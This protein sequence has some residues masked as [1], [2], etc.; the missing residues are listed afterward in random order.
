MA[1]T[2]KSKGPSPE[3]ARPFE[4]KSKG[5][6][7]TKGAPASPETARPT[8]MRETIESVVVAFILAFMFKTFEAE[9]F[10]RLRHSPTFVGLSDHQVIHAPINFE[11]DDL[12]HVL[13]NAGLD[14]TAPI[15]FVWEGVTNYLSAHAVDDTLATIR[16]FSA[17]QDA[18]LIVTY[19]DIRALDDHSPFPEAARWVKAV[20]DAGEPWTF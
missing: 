5:S 16:R 6:P 19:I 7:S 1:S 18:A 15:V 20:R 14:S 4:P 3:P 9:A 10:D 17:G 11:R 2:T 13:T 12:Y 8:A